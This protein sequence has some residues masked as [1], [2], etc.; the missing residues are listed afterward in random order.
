MLTHLVVESEPGANAG[1]GLGDCRIGVEVDLLV[2]E[3]SPQ[4]LDEDVVNAA[5]LAVQLILIPWRFR[6]PVKSS[7]VN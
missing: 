6:V 5:A 2:L 1:L 4:S 3:A 7:L